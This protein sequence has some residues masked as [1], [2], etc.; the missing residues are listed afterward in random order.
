[1][2]ADAGKTRTYDGKDGWLDL[3]SIKDDA[4]VLVG[5][6]VLPSEHPGVEVIDGALNYLNTTYPNGLTNPLYYGK[7]VTIGEEGENKLFYAFDYDTNEW[8]YL[9]T[10]NNESSWT[11]VAKEDD[12][13]LEIQKQKLAIGGVWFIVEGEDD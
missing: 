7:I 5:F 2:L 6:N 9:G 8:Y 12:S 4:G 3:G 1:M 13:I 11:M 10:F